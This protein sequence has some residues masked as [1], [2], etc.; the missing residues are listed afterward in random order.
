MADRQQQYRGKSSTMPTLLEGELGF[1]TDTK[2]LYIGTGSSNVLINGGGGSGGDTGD[3]EN[4]VEVLE[5]KVDSLT[6]GQI[7]VKLLD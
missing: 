6:M 1:C 3:L 4:R 2:K 5:G 7:T